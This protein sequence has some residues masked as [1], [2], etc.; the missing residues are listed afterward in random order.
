MPFLQVIN[1]IDPFVKCKLGFAVASFFSP[2]FCFISNHWPR[3]WVSFQYLHAGMDIKGVV[4]EIQKDKATP[5]VPKVYEANSFYIFSCNGTDIN[6]R[7]E[8]SK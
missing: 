8:V 1:L 3:D 2:L 5:L 7:N 6:K 4:A